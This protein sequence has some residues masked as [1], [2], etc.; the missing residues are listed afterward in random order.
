MRVEW[1]GQS[2]FSLS[3]K[4]AKVFIDPFAD[5]SGLAD[6]GLQFDYPPIEAIEVDLL[7]VTHEHGDHNGVEAV[8]G[9]PVTLRSTAGS[10]DSPLGEVT[11]IASEHDDVAG[12]MRGPN[13]IFAFE[14]DGLRVVHFGDFGQSSLRP[15]QAAAIGAVDLLFIPVGGGPTI[16]GV[17]AAE[18]TLSLNPTWVVPMHYR[19]PRISFLETEEEFVKAIAHVE[20]IDSPSFETAD[21]PS[22]DVALAVVP[23]AP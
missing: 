20:R 16:G 2:A 4:E 14:L 15:A 7:L 8:G 21:L 9:E 11:A 18:I 22:G 19:T 6:R 13:T 10:L 23:A 3:G 17:A 1:H 12:T 5:T